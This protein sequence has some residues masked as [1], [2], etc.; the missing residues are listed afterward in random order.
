M[1]VDY[2]VTARPIG[3]YSGRVEVADDATDYEIE[4][5]IKEELDFTIDIYR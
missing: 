4:E 3:S 5:K 1:W 2:E